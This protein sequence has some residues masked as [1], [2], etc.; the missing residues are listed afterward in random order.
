MAG[1][2]LFTHPWISWQLL[3]ELF[4]SGTKGEKKVLFDF[5]YTKKRI[6]GN[7]FS[8]QGPGTFNTARYR[9]I[10]HSITVESVMHVVI[11]I[12]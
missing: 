2:I 7:K 9:L 4:N 1:C 5:P 6:R 3:T 12:L 8:E 11:V 10:R